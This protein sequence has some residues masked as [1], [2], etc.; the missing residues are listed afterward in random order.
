MASAHLVPWNACF[1]KNIDPSLKYHGYLRASTIG[2]RRYAH[3]LDF[4]HELQHPCG[5]E[6][7]HLGRIR[8]PRN[9]SLRTRRICIGRVYVC[10]GILLNVVLQKEVKQWI[11]PKETP[12]IRRLLAES[13]SHGGLGMVV[14]L[15]VPSP[16]GVS[17]A[18]IGRPI[19]L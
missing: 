5:K 13:F 11:T 12:R 10:V 17:S 16:T 9:E 1:E 7:R 2:S 8:A 3:P 6:R 18:R 15:R 19:Q 14:T 4:L